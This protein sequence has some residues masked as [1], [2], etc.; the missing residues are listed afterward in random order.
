MNLARSVTSLS[1]RQ[2]LL[3]LNKIPFVNKS[4]STTGEPKLKAL[5]AHFPDAASVS[6]LVKCALPLQV[7]LCL[8]EFF[9]KFLRFSSMI[10]LENQR[11]NSWVFYSKKTCQCIDPM[12]LCTLS[13]I[14][15]S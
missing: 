3:H 7:F 2:C 4:N 14:I 9:V 13:M 1:D 6:C 12:H 11:K 10:I 8:Y 5:T 15:S